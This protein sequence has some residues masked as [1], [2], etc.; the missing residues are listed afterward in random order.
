MPQPG[1]GEIECRL[2]V[3][4]RA[5]H[6]GAPSNL[7]QNALEWIVIWHV[8]IGAVVHSSGRV[9]FL[10]T[11][12]PS[13]LGFASFE[14]RTFACTAI[15]VAKGQFRIHATQ[16]RTSLFEH[17]VGAGEQRRWQW[18]YGPGRAVGASNTS[19]FA[20]SVSS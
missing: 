6:A 4:E 20:P 9:R 5:D 2:P 18:P 10:V 8:L 1:R 15:S 17:L 3:R 13:D 7:A 14:K 12:R 19:Q 11:A 16:Q